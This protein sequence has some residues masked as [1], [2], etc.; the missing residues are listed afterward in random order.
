MIWWTN[1][2]Q[3]YPQQLRMEYQV[4]VQ[5]KE[6]QLSSLK[7]MLDR[8][9]RGTTQTQSSV[10]SKKTERRGALSVRGGYVAEDTPSSVVFM[11]WCLYRC[12]AN[13]PGSPAY[14]E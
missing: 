11:G 12:W 9:L 6:K 13:Y 7:F 14:R 3:G 10:F 2:N 4:K 5:L 1:T 8:L